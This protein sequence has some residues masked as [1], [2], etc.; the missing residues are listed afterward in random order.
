MTGAMTLT[1]DSVEDPK[2]STRA[3]AAGAPPGAPRAPERPHYRPYLDGLRA[4]AV[5]LVLAFHAGVHSFNG[6]FIGVDLFFVLSGYLVTKLLLRDL[7]GSGR[8]GFGR[9]YSRRFRRLLPAAFTALVVTAAVYAA[10]A[11]PADVANA[12]GGVR[13][14]F[15][16]VANWHFIR[17]SSDYFGA[18]INTNPVVHFWSLAIEEQFYLLWPL[19]L[20]ALYVAFRRS[21]R[22]PWN[23][24]RAAV[25][26]G[27]VVSMVYAL[28]EARHDLNRAYYGT[29]TRAYELLAGALL[30][31]TPQ[32]FRVLR[33]HRRA[34]AAAAAVGLVAMLLA[35]SSAVHVGP[36][37]R[38][39]LATLFTSVLI[40]GVETSRGIVRRVMSSSTLVYLGRI[41]YG[42]Y[43]W[44]WP[45][46]VVATLRYH[47]TGG[48][49]FLLAG[50]VSTG[51]ASLSFQVLE[52]RVRESRALDRRRA[53]VIAIGLSLSLVGGLVVAPRILD[54]HGG[55]GTAT[56]IGGANAAQAGG[57]RIATPKLDLSAIK[58]ESYGVRRCFHS[59]VDGCVVVRGSGV[60]VALVGDSHAL[61]MTPT[62]VEIAKRHSLTL[63]VFTWPNCPWVRGVVEAPALAST[64]VFST[65]RAHQEDWYTRALDEFNPSVVFLVHRGLDDPANASPIHEQAAGRLPVGNP[66]YETVVQQDAG[67]TIDALRA[68]GRKV[69]VL[70]PIPI[71]PGAFNPFTCLSGARFL[72]DCRYVATSRPTPLQRFYGGR[73]DGAHV[74][75]INIDRLVCPYFPIC[76]PIVDGKVVKKD[77][78]H[79]TAEYARYIAPSLD[80]LLVRQGILSR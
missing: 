42:T 20:S 51:L 43:L 11:S 60:R 32:V 52:R 37:T 26:V 7:G 35:A 57:W 44:H 46:I 73:A 13:S 69:V 4:L 40:V 30:A 75:A 24:V 34:M 38:G 45:V 62:F 65:C 77:P 18:D 53:L 63:A 5:Y 36:I 23:G 25:A 55:A 3:D 70:D 31:L 12:L 67:R 2:A 47:P 19:L 56:L 10:V 79:L 39:V 61:S 78:Q 49:L 21:R 27:L 15:L 6:G 17:Q 58:S 54:R 22:S 74:W 71:A 29:D 80:D 9:F 1:D 76:D 14:A 48:E 8:I 59:P 72:E 16:Y 50:L 41:S 28:L 66:R 64:S 68:R 33:R